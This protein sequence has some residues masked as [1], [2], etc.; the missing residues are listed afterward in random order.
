MLSGPDEGPH[1]IWSVWIRILA[2]TVY[3]WLDEWFWRQQVQS[4]IPASWMPQ[5]PH[6]RGP[7]RPRF[8][9]IESKQ[10]LLGLAAIALAST[11]IK[12]IGFELSWSQSITLFLIS[13]ALGLRSRERG[14]WPSGAGMI[15]GFLILVHPVAGLPVFGIDVS[16]LLMARTQSPEGFERWSRILCGGAGGPLASAALQLLLIAEIARRS[17]KIQFRR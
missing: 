2:I 3:C 16:G 4:R 15:A 7:D 14:E 17:L 8:Q 5:A 9:G 11:A 13:I 12:S 1:L 10:T 6:P